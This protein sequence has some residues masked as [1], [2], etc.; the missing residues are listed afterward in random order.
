[1]KKITVIF[2]S[3]FLLASCQNNKGVGVKELA[4]NFENPPEQSRP[5]VWWHW[6]NGN[7][8]KDGIRKDLE[9]MNRS[10]IRGF[11]HFDAALETP[12]V[13][14]ERLVYMTEPWKDAFR[15]PCM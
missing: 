5:M 10:G 12:Q 8:T 14:S 4:Q 1:M 7:I 11:H 13:V 9:W 6:M 3:A 15:M 2:L